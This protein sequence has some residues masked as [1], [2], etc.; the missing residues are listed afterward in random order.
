M[1]WAVSAFFVQF[2]CP[3]NWTVSC[4]P[5]TPAFTY[6]APYHMGQ[7]SFPNRICS[8]VFTEF[9]FL[10]TSFSSWEARVHSRA[11]VPPY[12]RSSTRVLFFFSERPTFV[13]M[14]AKK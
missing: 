1:L 8:Y 9:R 12:V 6:V 10:A 14:V 3:L 7:D 4:A 5:T 11:T 13:S 2:G